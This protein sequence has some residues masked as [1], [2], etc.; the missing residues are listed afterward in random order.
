[1]DMLKCLHCPTA[2]HPACAPKIVQRLGP[3]SKVSVFVLFGNGRIHV[4]SLHAEIASQWSALQFAH[5]LNLL[6]C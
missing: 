6:W 2:Y 3:A 5:H 1:M 4:K